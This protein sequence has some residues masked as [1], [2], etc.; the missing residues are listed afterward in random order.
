MSQIEQI[1]SVYSTRKQKFD[2]NRYIT[3]IQQYHHIPYKPLDVETPKGNNDNNPLLIPEGPNNNHYGQQQQQQYGYHG[4]MGGPSNHHQNGTIG[5]DK[6]DCKYNDVHAMY[7]YTSSSFGIDMEHNMYGRAIKMHGPSKYYDFKQEMLGHSICGL[8]QTQFNII[9]LK[10]SIL[11]S[12]FQGKLL[13]SRK[14][15]DGSASFELDPKLY[16]PN[17]YMS[18][19]M[20]QALLIYCG[21]E[22]L[23]CELMKTY[24][25]IRHINETDNDCRRR[26]Y[27]IF[28]HWGKLLYTAIIAFG[29]DIYDDVNNNNMNSSFMNYSIN[30]KKRKKQQKFYYHNVNKPILFT[31][32]NTSFYG[33]TS[34]TTSKN[35][36]LIHMPS[37]QRDGI[38]LELDTNNVGWTTPFYLNISM[39]GNNPS[40]LEQLFHGGASLGIHNI[41]S[42][43]HH[44]ELSNLSNYT[45]A[46]TLLRYIIGDT[47][48][49]HQQFAEQQQV[50]NQNGN[51]QQNDNE[52]E[53]LDEFDQN[54]C[55]HLEWLIDH[56]VEIYKNNKN[57][58]E[59]KN[60]SSDV[61]LYIALVLNS[62]CLNKQ[63][64]IQLNMKLLRKLPG[65]L[66][67]KFV[68]ESPMDLG[69]YSI[70]WSVIFNLFP[71][72]N[73]I[74]KRGLYFNNYLCEQ[75]VNF[76]C[77][78]HI[79]PKKYKMDG[80]VFSCTAETD[81]KLWVTT[82]KK[83]SSIIKQMGWL[84]T[85][86]PPKKNAFGAIETGRVSFIKRINNK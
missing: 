40:E 19:E 43:Y 46:I 21:Y 27:S 80:I 31:K 83:H 5:G 82:A 63:G 60:F 15:H 59:F 35:V 75:Y 72:C 76:L 6:Q 11:L 47:N 39:F 45:S 85:A 64:I 29:T 8:S 66:Q 84:I 2:Q 12:T 49:S 25:K 48:N 4:T 30:N 17:E 20:C 67:H 26:H 32:F 1:K 54:I 61:P 37:Q 58:N 33:P 41:I 74:W 78:E 57:I 86:S 50:I 7:E 79:T 3:N 28:Y 42:I 36:A 68:Y 65:P 70:N 38:V 69:D 62:W 22:S 18:E 55:K 51:H 77:S 34:C 10:A 73:K 56:Q 53:I 13:K 71:N 9:T 44:K 52:Q 16:R 81:W 23:R 24:F 14:I